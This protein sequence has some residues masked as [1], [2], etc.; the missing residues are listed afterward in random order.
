MSLVLS[1][2]LKVLPNL[3]VDTKI[4]YCL[5]EG[6]YSHLLLGSI[7]APSF[8]MALLLKVK[9]FNLMEHVSLLNSVVKE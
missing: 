5:R 1:A 4:F 2:L 9:R 3:Q 6:A 7:H 8:K